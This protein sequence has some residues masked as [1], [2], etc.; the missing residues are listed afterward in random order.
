M[1]RTKDNNYEQGYYTGFC[2]YAIN[3]E[4]K[5]GK[6]ESLEPFTSP[7]TPELDSPD[8]DRRRLGLCSCSAKSGSS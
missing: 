5:P 4:L 1:N 8:S 2:Q 3:S 7:R 6:S